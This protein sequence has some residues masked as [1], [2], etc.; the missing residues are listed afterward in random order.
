MT[1]KGGRI[2]SWKRRWFC[3][4]PEKLEYFT[5]QDKKA[6]KGSI[7]L[8]DVI[9]VGHILH[10]TRSHCI[11]IRTDKRL[12]VVSCEDNISFDAWLDKLMSIQPKALDSEVRFEG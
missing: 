1:K 12:Y 3:L 9:E 2:A 11:G 8:A 5:D 4:G 7:T 6:L 10:E